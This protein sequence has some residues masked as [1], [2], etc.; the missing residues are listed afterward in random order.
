MILRTKIQESI[1]YMKQII[2]YVDGKSCKQLQ[3]C[4]L[5]TGNLLALKINYPFILSKV[6]VTHSLNGKWYQFCDLGQSWYHPKI[7]PKVMNL[8]Q[9]VAQYLDVELRKPEMTNNQ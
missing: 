6:Q 7:S 9:I 5:G 4:Y 2:C 8:K 1:V 3:K